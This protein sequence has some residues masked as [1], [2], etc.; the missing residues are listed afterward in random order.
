VKILFLGDIMGRPGRLAIRELLPRLIHQHRADLVIAN[1]E[2]ACGGMG[3]TPE[4]AEELFSWEVDVLTSGNHIWHKRE[5]LDYLDQNPRI[6]RPANFPRAP[7]RG[8]TIVE[9]P[10]GDRVGVI[11][12]QG[13]AFMPQYVDDPFAAADRLID[14]LRHREVRVIVV[15]VHAEATS[16]KVAM[17][18]YLDGRVSAVLGTHTHVQ[19]CDEEVLP[20]GT[21]RI[22]DVGMTGPHDSVIGM[23]T[24]LVVE[25][26]LTQR[27]V[28]FEVAKGGVRAEGVIL[29][30]DAATGRARSIER[31]REL[32]R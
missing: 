6:L 15:D 32:L 24:D 11:N 2:N 17:A 18:R 26:F 4:A 28:G 21:A 7:G 8:H 5:I 27:H 10:G 25:R 3:I 22:C 23:R 19:T 31:V 12:V 9:T 13:R 30:I 16:E 14:E 20:K 29:D 1:C